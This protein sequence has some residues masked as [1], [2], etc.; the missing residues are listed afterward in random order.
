[1]QIQGMESIS[2]IKSAA[3][4]QNSTGA[5]GQGFKQALMDALYSAS[6][7]EKEQE[8][9][10]EKFVLGELD[11]LHDLTIATQ[12][13]DVA[14]QTIVEIRNKIVDAYKEIMRMQI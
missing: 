9:L 8:M 2:N 10:G 5:N 4:V 13:A 14:V 12:K 7:L 11:N 1:M 6:D 3:G